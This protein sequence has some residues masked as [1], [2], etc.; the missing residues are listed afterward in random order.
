[1]HAA[2]LA[3]RVILVSP[4]R[5]KL[6]FCCDFGVDLALFTRRRVVSERAD[7]HAG[8]IRARTTALGFMASVAC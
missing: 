3:H 6:R 2:C 8:P 7:A 1:M 4:S 5:R